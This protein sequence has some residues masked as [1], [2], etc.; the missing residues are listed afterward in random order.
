[1]LFLQKNHGWPRNWGDGAKL[2]GGCAPWPGP[3]TATASLLL[4]LLL[5]MMMMQYNVS[6]YSCR[7]IGVALKILLFIH[8]QNEAAVVDNIHRARKKV[9]PHR[10]C[11]EGMSHLNRSK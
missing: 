8:K 5:M 3:K 1:V 4:L 2:G 7:S 6:R 9:T 11:T 10:Q